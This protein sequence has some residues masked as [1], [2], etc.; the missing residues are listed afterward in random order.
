MDMS[1]FSTPRHAVAVIG[2]ACSGAEA[3]ETFANA[4]VFAVVFD[5]NARPFGKIEDG[6]PRWH[7]KQ[8]RDRSRRHAERQ[9]V[10]H[11][12]RAVPRVQFFGG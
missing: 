12:R 6:L 11:L 1:Q 2:A 8:R 10:Q 4:G 9:T 3:A 7:A 5:Q